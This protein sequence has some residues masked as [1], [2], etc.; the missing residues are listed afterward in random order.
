MTC[1]NGHALAPGATRCATCGAPAVRLC[2]NGHPLPAGYQLCSQCGAFAVAA[3]S[4]PTEPPARVASAGLYAACGAAV[5]LALLVVGVL[6][7]RS[8][9]ASQ[10]QAAPAT[11]KATTKPSTTTTTTTTTTRPRLTTTTRA[12]ANDPLDSFEITPERLKEELRK[13]G[14]PPAQ[15][16]CI[17]DGLVAEGID[18]STFA[19]PTD[20]EQR[21]LV[22]IASRCASQR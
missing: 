8:A 3:T 13:S 1:A 4:A 17:V 19:N 12:P 11:T 2:A 14:V 15:A 5:L 10:V 22:D 21:T 9:P 16:D 18:L 7:V 20:E 6:I